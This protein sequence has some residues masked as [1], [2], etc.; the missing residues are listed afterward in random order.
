MPSALGAV[1]PPWALSPTLLLPQL[2][3]PAAATQAEGRSLASVPSGRNV[4]L[5][6]ALSASSCGASGL[7]SQVTLS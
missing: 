4:F 2:L 7:D 3:S 1:P 6:A 5:P